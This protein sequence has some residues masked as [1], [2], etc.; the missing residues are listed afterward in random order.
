MTRR[1]DYPKQDL[2]TE[3]VNKQI[4]GADSISTLIQAPSVQVLYVS[5]EFPFSHM[6]SKKR[7]VTQSYLALICL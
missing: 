5:L 2:S 7:M 4:L 1:R 6:P 3:S